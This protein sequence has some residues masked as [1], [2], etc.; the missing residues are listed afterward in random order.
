M[1]ISQALGK[2]ILE[3]EISNIS[4]HG[5]WLV[6]E[7]HE[8]FLPFEQFPWFRD[9]KLD[10]ILDVQLLHEHHLHWPKLDIDLE[11]VPLNEEPELGPKPGIINSDSEGLSLEEYFQRFILEHQDQMSETELARKLG[12]SR[13][14][15]WERRQRLGIPRKK[16][17]N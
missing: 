7:D 15:L 14:S 3:V 13:K 11:L 1:I 17:Q 6:V 5:L 9:A 10:E 2:A 8:Y 12:V 4:T 16:K